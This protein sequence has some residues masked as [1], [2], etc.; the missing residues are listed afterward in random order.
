MGSLYLREAI[1]AADIAVEVLCDRI[2]RVRYGP[3]LH[4]P[5]CDIPRVLIG[6]SD[7]VRTASVL[8]GNRA[9]RRIVTP[10]RIWLTLFIDNAGQQSTIPTTIGISAHHTIRIS[11]RRQS[12]SGRVVAVTNQCSTGQYDRSDSIDSTSGTT[13]LIVV[14]LQT[15]SEVIGDHRNALALIVRDCL[16]L[17]AAVAYG[18][19][20]P[21]GHIGLDGFVR[22]VE[23]LVAAIR[24]LDQSI[25]DISLGDEV[26]LIEIE[27]S[28]LSILAVCDGARHRTRC[29]HINGTLVVMSPLSSN[30][31]HRHQA[32]ALALW[33]HGKFSKL[34]VAQPASAPLPI[35]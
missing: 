20:M 35:D 30:R 17:P 21:I 14:E 29:I 32:K 33:M 31:V 6:D 8:T 15:V 34:T 26:A 24:Q 16:R 19:E 7:P 4:L 9:C 5:W 12:A 18:L 3:A 13:A 1:R 2:L 23:K 22:C 27:R 11:H 28:Y 10:R 25:I